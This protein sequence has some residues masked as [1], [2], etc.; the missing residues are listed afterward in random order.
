M[1]Y[2]SFYSSCCVLVKSFQ[3]ISLLCLKTKLYHIILFCQISQLILRFMTFHVFALTPFSPYVVFINIRMPQ[4]PEKDF[5]TSFQ[6]HVQYII[7]LCNLMCLEF[8]KGLYHINLFCNALLQFL[9]FRILRKSSTASPK[10]H[11]LLYYIFIILHWSLLYFC[12]SQLSICSL[13]CCNFS[14]LHLCHIF[15]TYHTTFS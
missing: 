12:S 6:E 14:K 7:L 13:V 5:I 9:F 1:F 11:I 15:E 8:R 10:E 2:C 3:K 4:I